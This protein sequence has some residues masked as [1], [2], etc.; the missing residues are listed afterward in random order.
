MLRGLL[1]Y[2]LLLCWNCCAPAQTDLAAKVEAFTAREELRGAQIGISVVEVASGRQL[3]AYRPFTAHIPASTQKLVTTAA[4]A[5]LLGV[6]HR[7]TTRLVYTGELTDDGTLRGNVYIVGGGDPTL[8]SPYMDGVLRLPEV[9]A[10]WRK[11]VTDAGIDRIEGRIVGDA[12]Y[13]G[14]DGPAAGWPWADLGNYYGAGAYGLNIHENSYS[15]DLLQ[16][17]KQGATP[18]VSGTRPEVTGLTIKNELISGPPGSGDQAYLFASPFGATAYLRGSIPAGSGRFTIRGS[19]PDPAL[20]AA[21][22]LRE[23]L[24]EAGIP[25]A[26]PPESSTSSAITTPETTV[27]LDEYHSPPLSAIIDRTNLRSLNLYAEALLRE[28]NKARGAA[29]RDLADAR[30]LTDWLTER[31]IATPSTYLIDGSGLSPR[32]FLS[33]ALLTNLLRTQAGNDRWRAS[34]PLA[35]RTGSMRNFLRKRVAAGRLSA[36]SG[37]LEAVRCYAG[38]ATTSDGRELAFAIMVNNHT[39]EG[40][41]LRGWMLELMNDLCASSAP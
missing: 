17:P 5:D 34:I 2:T 38:Y 9:L 11:A 29:T 20:L 35:G 36:K 33:P 14:T 27:L 26:L 30:L 25:V 23:A 7:F 13:Y 31:G 1:S 22:L 24:I 16:R 19:L 37:S 41:D 39:V 21:R 12:T 6:D 32:N 8:A 4:A 18:L 15:L 10:R 3:A 40:R 28:M